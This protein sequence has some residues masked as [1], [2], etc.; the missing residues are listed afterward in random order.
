MGLFS[1]LVKAGKKTGKSSRKILSGGAGNSGSFF[2]SFQKRAKKSSSSFSLPKKPKKPRNPSASLPKKPK[3]PRNPSAPN[4]KKPKVGSAAEAASGNKTLLRSAGEAC[5]KKPKKCAAVAAG[6]AL[7]GYTAYK[8]VENTKEQQECITN[9]LPE[10][11]AQVQY[12]NAQGVTYFTE[13]QVENEK[14]EPQPQ[15]TGGDCET[16]CKTECEK[17]HPTT[18]IG[19]ASEALSDVVDK[20]LVPFLEDF[21][22]LPITSL[23]GKVFTF[24]RIAFGLIV[25]MVAY[26]IYSMVRAALGL[27]KAAVRTVKSVARSEEAMFVM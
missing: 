12:G 22:G 27:T 4:K 11:W 16:F 9:C 6:V 18:V 26:R 3:K 10:E 7:A 5:Q 25:L 23:S 14:G 21:I 15:C 1:N 13:A 17:L 24:I 19:A 2:K 20:A 8:F